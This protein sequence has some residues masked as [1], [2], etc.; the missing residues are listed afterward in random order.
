MNMPQ[1]AK[2]TQTE[3]TI[4]ILPPYLINRIAAG[5]VV[6]RPASVI[7]ELVENALDAGATRID[8]SASNAGRNMRVA[9]NGGGMTPQNAAMAFYNHATSKIHHEADLDRIATLGFRGEALASIGSISKLTCLTRAADA[10]VGTRVTLDDSG[11]PVLAEAGCAPGTVMEV[12]DLFYNTPARLKFLKRAQTELGHIEET[13]QYLALSH[14]EVRFSLTL[15]DKEVLKTSGTNELKRT[16]EEALGLK[17][18]NIPWVPVT[19]EDPDIGLRLAGF[20][21]EPGVMKSSKRWLITYL[22]GRYVRCAILQKAIEAAYESLLPH[23]KY[24]VCVFFLSMPPQDVD[25]NVH[26]TKREVRY[27]SGNTIFGFVRSGLRNSLAAHG[28]RLDAPPSTPE[29]AGFS[30]QAF[31]TASFS[32]PS[33]SMMSFPSA[34]PAGSMGQQEWRVSP[35]HHLIKPTL[36]SGSGSPPAYRRVPAG[37]PQPVQ[38]AL[39]FYQPGASSPLQPDS[40]QTEF[41]A[42]EKPVFANG[43]FKVIGQLFN[44]YI[45][46]ETVQGLLVVDQHIASER[47]FFES[48]T[49]NLSAE[50]PDIQQ[51]V[52]ALPLAISPVQR[53]LLQRYQPEFARLGFLYSLPDEV[54]QSVQ[55]TGYPLV[56]AG[57]DGMFQAG[58]LFENLLAQLEETGEMKLDL[59]H[60]IATLA[61]HSAVRAGDALNHFEMEQ[62]IDRWL[63][64]QLPWTCPHGR[65]IAHTISTSELNHFFHRP[66]LPVNAI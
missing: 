35:Q 46:L 12:L 19:A 22:N 26:P 60:L 40:P 31:N 37:D 4:R 52:T 20:V 23:G 53:D 45:L 57:R 21:S 29:E 49:L 5:E 39:G 1:P 16:L 59:D 43:K 36:G 55:L 2:A 27:A 61:C 17:R 51:M 48:L 6:E 42:A 3:R 7:K 62:V 58:G 44:T 15:N 41:P 30:N 14:P 56:Y 47:D 11:E 32:Q 24:P 8:I 18:E 38:A 34:P 54:A 66:S 64:C 33:A 65:P 9:D 63:A 25:V 28:I 13:V 50:A 10:P